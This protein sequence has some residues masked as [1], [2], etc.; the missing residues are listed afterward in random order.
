MNDFKKGQT[1]LV[2][3]HNDE[4]W[5]ARTYHS[6]SRT[7]SVNGEEGWSWDQ[8][9]QHEGNE[10]LAGTTDPVEAKPKEG[11]LWLLKL[12]DD[13]ALL[14]SFRIDGEWRDF[15]RA[16]GIS[17]LDDEVTLICKLEYDENLVK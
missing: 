7:L 4:Y 13:D 5:T 3:D 1:I 15:S 17:A 2:R 9:I 12:K 6:N 16:G 8:M 14:A 10:H 11:E